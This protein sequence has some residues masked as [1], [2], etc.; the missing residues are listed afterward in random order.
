[1]IAWIPL[2]SSGGQGRLKIPVGQRS[3]ASGILP[4]LES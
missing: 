4:Y 1:M 2:C 3:V